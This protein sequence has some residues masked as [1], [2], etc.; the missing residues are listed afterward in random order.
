MLVADSLAVGGAE[1]T[2][3]PEIFNRRMKKLYG[4]LI[5]GGDG[6]GAGA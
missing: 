4:L 5:V 1:S 2:N 3:D 6:S